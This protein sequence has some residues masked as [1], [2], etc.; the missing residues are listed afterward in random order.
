MNNLENHFSLVEDRIEK[1][2]RGDGVAAIW[3]LNEF[4]A[5]VMNNRQRGSDGSFRLDNDGRRVPHVKPSGIHT[6]FDERLLDYLADCFGDIGSFI[7]HADKKRKKTADIALNLTAF[8]P[9]GPKAKS[10]TREESLRRGMAAW[11]KQRDSQISI[12]LACEEVAALE[13]KSADTIKRD[14]KAFK[15]LVS[16]ADDELKGMHF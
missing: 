10:S 8:G 15:K 9:R 13:N 12:E 6:E 2:K 1:A 4:R 11:L 14:Y 16:L 5:S 7:D 3:L